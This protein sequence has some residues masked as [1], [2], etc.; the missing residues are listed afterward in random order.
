[1]EMY[2][3]IDLCSHRVLNHRIIDPLS[4]LGSRNLR[5]NT[6]KEDRASI[7]ETCF[8]EVNDV[9]VCFNTC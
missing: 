1:M 6:R 5:A 7:A 4:L 9:N 2:T 8:R 3:M